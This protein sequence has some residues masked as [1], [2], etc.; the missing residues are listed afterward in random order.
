MPCLSRS[1]HGINVVSLLYFSGFSAR[2]DTHQVQ[3][4]VSAHGK[5]H[6]NHFV[7]AVPARI[8]VAAATT[9]LLWIVIELGNINRISV[10]IWK[11]KSV[12]KRRNYSLLAKSI[13]VPVGL[14]QYERSG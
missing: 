13:C 11:R 14:D 4:A 2:R 7:V 8:Q 12:R 9:D 6:P 5:V 3:L 10:D 1:Y